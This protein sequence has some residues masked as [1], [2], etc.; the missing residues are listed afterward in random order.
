MAAAVRLVPGGPLALVSEGDFGHRVTG[1][2]AQAVPDSCQVGAAGLAGAFA[3]Q[4]ATVVVVLPRAAWGLCDTA[5]EFAYAQGKPWLP[6]VLEHPVLRIGPLVLPPSG[7]CFGC[8][9]ARRRQH[10][11]AR[12]ASAVLE[13][14]YDADPALAP[15]GYLPHHARLAAAVISR[16]LAGSETG[17]VY[18]YNVLSSR[19]SAHRVIS[20]HDCDR[21][22]RESDPP[23]SPGLAGVARTTVARS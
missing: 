22:P 3:G 23:R 19:G 12:A 14:G 2:L 7:P 21:E 5:D 13:S 18:A 8:Y 20:C 6:A 10:D 1:L 9:R 11:T 15:A 4:A 17:Q 16:F